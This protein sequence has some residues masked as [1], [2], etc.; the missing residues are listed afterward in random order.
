MKAIITIL[1]FLISFN[2][3]YA[4]NK[5]VSTID[6]NIY[7]RCTD[8]E[9]T[10]DGGFIISGTTGLNV[11][12]TEMFYLKIDENYLLDWSHTTS[13]APYSQGNNIVKL[14]NTEYII[15]GHGIH[16]TA[17]YDA[18]FFKID[19]DGEIIADYSTLGTSHD[20]WRVAVNANNDE[21]LLLF[22]VENSEKVIKKIDFNNN[23]IWT[24]N[25]SFNIKDLYLK[26]NEII[27]ASTTPYDNPSFYNQ[28]DLIKYDSLGNQLWHQQYGNYQS[29][30]GK[31]L[32]H[33]PDNG[34]LFAGSV[35]SEEE[36]PNIFLFKADS[37]GNELWQNSIGD[38]YNWEK[39]ND[40]I[41]INSELYIV[42]DR[43]YDSENI[44]NPIL[45]KLDLDGNI[46]WEKE[47]PFENAHAEI[48][49][50]IHTDDDRLILAGHIGDKY[51]PYE[52]DILLIETDLNGLITSSTIIDNPA[53]KAIISP[54]PSCNN[55]WISINSEKQ[56]KE[57]KI[58]NLSGSLVQQLPF[59]E[60][61][62]VSSLSAGNY[63]IQ[64]IGENNTHVEKLII[65]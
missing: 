55:I 7:D 9:T 17:D 10:A 41:I 6:L 20:Y 62:D 8:I 16:H 56:F 54:N 30:S 5:Q 50:I 63:I 52:N 14:N 32:L 24:S 44:V 11:Y 26:N 27:A 65:H 45:L 38:E 42:G 13:S 29:Y 22:G 25:T 46:I 12:D 2:L 47:Y 37:L 23:E 3:L 31:T 51:S 64:L 33:T 59:S 57:I 28:L 61:L 15:N 36:Y 40:A 48:H 60:Y 1:F 43:R 21:H 49:S 39:C 19:I 4:Q 34:I 53:T 18:L 35:G 58:F